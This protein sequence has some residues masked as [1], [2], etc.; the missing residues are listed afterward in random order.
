MKLLSD[1]QDHMLELRT[2]YQF[3]DQRKGKV[4]D[5]YKVN[6]TLKKH[7]NFNNGLSSSSYYCLQLATDLLIQLKTHANR[8]LLLKGS[9][10]PVWVNYIV[11]N[12]YALICNQLYKYAQCLATIQ[13]KNSVYFQ[14]T[15]PLLLRCF[16]MFRKEGVGDERIQCVLPA[17][18]QPSLQIKFWTVFDLL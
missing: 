10:R 14:D 11:W 15:A 2:E 8:E 18:D 17:K 3:W 12:E 9:L 4:I 5:T 16:Q 7:K 1:D 6:L 13:S